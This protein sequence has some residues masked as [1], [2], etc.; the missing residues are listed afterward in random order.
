MRLCFYNPHAITNA[1]GNTVLSKAAQIFGTN[2]NNLR[3]HNLKYEFVLH[4]L[5]DSRYRTALVVDGAGTSFSTVLNKIPLIKNAYFL[6]RIVSYIE[7]YL[8]CFLND[9][10]PWKQEII[11]SRK[12]LD[13]KSDI[14]FSYAFC[15]EM[16][17]SDRLL[18]R[19]IIKSFEGK[20]I[21]HASH[22]YKS[23]KKIAQNIQKTGTVYM[24][25]EAD[26]K[27]SPYFNTFFGFIKHVY[28]LPHVLRK[29]YVK[30]QEFGKRK[31]ICLALGTLVIE[32]ESDESNRDHFDFFK[33]NT[34]HPMR[35]QVFENK[36]SLTQLI[37]CN[38]N[39]HNKDRIAI[40]NKS[41]LY[42]KSD[43]FR[44]VYDLFFLSEGK[45]Y[46]K[47]DIVKKYNEYKMFLSAEENIGLSSVNFIEGMACGCAYIGVSHPMYSD[48]GMVDQ[49]HYIAYDG[50]L[51]DLR[52][53]IDYYQ[54][55][56]AALEQIAARGHEFALRR[57]SEEKVVK[58]FFVYLEHL[59]SEYD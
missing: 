11:F 54:K 35:K 25:A 24:V 29:R 39:F 1:V 23:T 41:R 31:N 44:L 13:K 26:L 47:L 58:D 5:K 14:L 32:D 48:L 28:I 42:K 6:R 34:L 21:L 50:T 33:I 7:I 56:P 55:H 53:K 10:S 36:D 43:I 27:K 19:S 46:H 15:T 16:F 9:L 49:E 37:D 17:F 22:F 59:V 4:F 18:E 3:K 40:G 51:A 52:A 12:K 20:K 57:F 2:K 45:E 8:W 38:I 30:T